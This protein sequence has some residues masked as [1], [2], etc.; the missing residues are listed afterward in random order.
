MGDFVLSLFMMALTPWALAL[1]WKLIS[2]IGDLI[3]L[4]LSRAFEVA[5]QRRPPGPLNFNAPS[6]CI[7][8][9]GKTP[10]RCSG[11]FSAPQRQGPS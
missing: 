6:G 5:E 11:R 9:A 4:R 7:S 2:G 3:G 8:M 1:A 10:I